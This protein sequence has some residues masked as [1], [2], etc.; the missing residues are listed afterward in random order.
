[1]IPAN[2]LPRDD[3]GMSDPNREQVKTVV[4]E[5]VR[6]SCPCRS[7]VQHDPRQH[8]ECAWAQDLG[9]AV[10]V[11]ILTSADPAVLDAMQD[12]LVRAGR[13]TT[14]ESQNPIYGTQFRRLVTEW[15]EAVP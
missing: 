9:H 13:L 15:T 5:A 6:L 10:S 7:V 14:E 2:P 12:A 4:T 8:I 11:R 3:A 1:M